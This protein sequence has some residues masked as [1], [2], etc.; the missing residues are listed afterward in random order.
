MT[1]FALALAAAIAAASPAGAQDYPSRPVTVIGTTPAGTSVDLT[2]RFFGEKVKDKTGQPW[3]IEN[4]PG[5][6]GSI[7]AKAAASAKPDGYTAF[8]C[9][10][11][12]LS[13]N[14]YLQ[15]NLAYDPVKDFT[16]V[17]RLFRLDFV[18]AVN[19]QVTPVKTVAELTEF[20]KAKKGRVSYGYFS[21]SMQALGEQYLA[22][23]GI[24]GAPAAYKNPAQMITELEAGDYDFSFTSAEYALVPNPRLRILAIAAEKRSQLLP[25][26]PTLT[27]AGLAKA[28]PLFSWFGYCMPAGVP[29]SV[30][31]TMTP[32]LTAIASSEEVRAFL[33]TYAG[34]PFPG[35]GAALA[36]TQADTAR[37]WGYFVKLANITAQ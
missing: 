20:L 8:I 37:D 26:V 11:G 14:Q 15:K 31:K 1:R 12:A 9:P 33:K 36:R 7:A 28:L 24:K 29:D 13:A 4:K 3:V 25:D 27:E 35:D 5:A 2:T 32:I 16:P 17:A 23:A 30:V 18:L 22:L 10:S 6:A 19:P 34:E 21:A